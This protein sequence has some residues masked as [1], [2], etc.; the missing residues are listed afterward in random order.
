[1]IMIQITVCRDCQNI[2]D[3]IKELNKL[4][5]TIVNKIITVEKK[6]GNV[7]RKR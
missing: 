5:L 2:V 3:K 7:N 4:R 1:M 6:Y